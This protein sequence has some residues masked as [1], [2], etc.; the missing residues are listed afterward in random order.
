MALGSQSTV[1]LRMPHCLFVGFIFCFVFL[2]ILRMI[3]S[4]ERIEVM[5]AL[6]IKSLSTGPVVGCKSLK[7]EK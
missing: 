3:S 7:I 1:Y 5:V 6:M 2:S 4:D